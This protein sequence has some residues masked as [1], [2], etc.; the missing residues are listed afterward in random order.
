DTG[1]VLRAIEIEA[2]GILLAK[3]IDGVYD[4]DPAVH[5]DAKRFETISI[6][7]VIAQ[8]L[9][10]VDMTASILARDYH[11][12]MRV[13]ALK[14]KDSIVQAATGTFRGTTVSA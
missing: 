14:E 10:A 13:F 1:V 11:M 6:E 7:E 3:N 12:P 9:Q 8:N 2:D 4:K 5:P